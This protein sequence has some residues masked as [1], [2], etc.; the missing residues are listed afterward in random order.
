MGLQSSKLACL[1]ALAALSGADAYLLGGPLPATMTAQTYRARPLF[2]QME[3]Q[4]MIV[5][6]ETYGLMLKTLLETENDLAEEISTNYAMIDYGFLQ[7]LEQTTSSDDPAIK[8]RAAAVQNAV[9]A[10]MAKRMQEH[11]PAHRGV[12]ATAATPRPPHPPNSATRR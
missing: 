11:T 3:Q 7:R 10:E 2:M 6:D 9:N 1:A 5:A 4:P 12:C 8:E